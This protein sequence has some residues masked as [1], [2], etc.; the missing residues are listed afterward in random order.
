[1]VTRAASSLQL[2]VD[3]ENECH[4][5]SL[6]AVITFFEVFCWYSSIVFYLSIFCAFKYIKFII[7]CGLID[8]FLPCPQELCEHNAS[9]I[10][11][12]S[13]IIPDHMNLIALKNIRILS[14]FSS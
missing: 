13:A 6:H 1:M 5:V 4:G 12:L 10:L 11:S 14:N 9:T 3:S 8:K 7:I 2:S